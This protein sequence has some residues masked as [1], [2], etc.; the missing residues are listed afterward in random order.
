MKRSL[1]GEHKQLQSSSTS[2][3]VLEDGKPLL[4]TLDAPVSPPRRKGRNKKVSD[5]QPA[6]SFSSVTADSKLPSSEPS[7]AAIE[8]GLVEVTD[9]LKIFSSR[10]ARCARPVS[11]QVPRLPIRDWVELYERNLHPN[12]RHFVIHQHD[13]P[14]A[15]PHYDLRLQFSET[16]SVSWSIMYGLPGDP[17]SRRLNR[18]ATET[19]PLNLQNHLIET[20]S[21]NTGSMII[22]DTGEYE[23]LPSQSA[24]EIVET[25]DSRS[26]LSDSSLHSHVYKKTESEKLREAFRN[27][28]IR[29]RLHG[30]RLPENYTI[31]L[32]LDKNFDFAKPSTRIPRKRRRRTIRSSTTRPEPSTSSDSEIPDREPQDQSVDADADTM[33]S[34]SEPESAI[35]RQ[36]RMNNAYPGSTNT[37][38]SIHQ[39]RWFATLDRVNSGFVPEHESA[40]SGSGK[41]RWVRKRNLRTGQELG[42]EPFYVR[43][44]EVERSVVTGRLGKDVLEDE[45]VKHFVPRRGWRAVVE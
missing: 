2:H 3:Q 8:A 24:R 42:F 18:N 43:G 37:I 25:D 15:G 16:S 32:R 1:N 4:S 9:H 5:D 30:T 27:N 13:H 45:G 10:L 35:D 38:G 23:I 33:A 31:I 41:K 29:L 14:I 40:E 39:R 28:K 44:P 20:A 22:W 26:E 19:R 11:P 21:A 17:N 12:G 7:L 6:P 36:I 34:H